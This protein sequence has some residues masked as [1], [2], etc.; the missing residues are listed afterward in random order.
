MHPNFNPTPE[1]L[2]PTP[3]TLK[4]KPHI[5]DPTPQTLN[6]KPSTLNPTPYT[7]HP[8]YRILHRDLSSRTTSFRSVVCLL[9]IG[10]VSVTPQDPPPRPQAGQH[11]S[12]PRHA[13][14][15]D[16]RFRHGAR[17]AGFFFIKILAGVFTRS[18]T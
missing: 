4:P 16:R 15:Q 3:E 10:Y 11:P 14:V 2:H 12:R 9:L 13:H 7:L 5:Q 1:T 8:I 17:Y 18:G 6:P